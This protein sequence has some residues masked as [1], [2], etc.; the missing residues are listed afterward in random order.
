MTEIA[1][2][3][4]KSFGPP[5]TRGLRLF[6][7]P[8]RARLCLG[9]DSFDVD[10]QEGL[11]TYSGGPVGNDFLAFYSA[12]LLIWRHSAAD[13]FDFAR[14]FPFEDA[15]SGT[16]THLP[17]PYPPH[18]LLL[19]RTAGD[20]ALFA[21]ALFLDR[22][23]RGAIRDDREEIVRPR[24]A[25]DRACAAVGPERDR[26]PERRPNGVAIR[27]RPDPV[28]ESDVRRWPRSVRLAFL[29]APG[30][31]LDTDLPARGA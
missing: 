29:Q 23:D 21:G 9:R 13:I 5:I 10:P 2:G 19:Y 7:L 17:C 26:W 3:G 8:R 27:G 12:S 31:R 18:F 14:L 11:H 25:D 15:F 16:S 24:H 22:R 6:P 1:K 20:D 28:G 30:L 4:S